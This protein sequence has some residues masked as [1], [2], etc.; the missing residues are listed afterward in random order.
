VDDFLRHKEMTM[1]IVFTH[2]L[3][4]WFGSWVQLVP[5]I[6]TAMVGYTIHGSVL[7]SIV[8]WL[9]W[10]IAIV[11]WLVLHQVN[12]SVLERTFGFLLQ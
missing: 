7:W 2:W 10:P 5:R 12:R 11:K 4:S 6:L 1:R 8:D 3:E 9:L